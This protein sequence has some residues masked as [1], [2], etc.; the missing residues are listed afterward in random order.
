[1]CFSAAASFITAGATGA[2]GIAALSRTHRPRERALAATPLL[3]AAQQAVE[4][5][6]WLNRPAAADGSGSTELTLLYLL[7][8]DVLWPVYAPIMVWLIEPS[9]WR[10]RFMLFWLAVGGCVAAF[11]L[12]WIFARPHGAM[13]LDGHIA[14]V[15]DYKHSEAISLAYLGATCVPLVLSSQRT[16]M[17][18]GTIILVGSAVAYAYY[19]ETFTSVWCFFAAAASVLVLGHFERM[20]RHRLR[21]ARA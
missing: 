10:R 8:A 20:R 12:W 19:W 16:V 13:I 3:F 14:Y 18:L 6:Q 2:V 15:P 5:L 1:M 7:F 17:A 21:P 11:F 9:A 4:G